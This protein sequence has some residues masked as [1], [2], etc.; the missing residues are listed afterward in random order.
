MKIEICENTFW[1]SL[2]TVITAAIT[3]MILVGCF[4]YN[5]RFKTAINAGYIENTVQGTNVL[6]WTK[7]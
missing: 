5:E 2:W 3:T 4:T 1:L 7:E 6:V